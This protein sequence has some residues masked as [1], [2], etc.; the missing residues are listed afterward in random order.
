MSVR[1]ILFVGLLMC[2]AT[3]AHAIAVPTV[4]GFDTGAADWRGLTTAINPTWSAT[5]GVEGGFIST[6]QAINSSSQP[7]VFRAQVNAADPNGPVNSSNGAFAGNWLAAGADKVKLSVKH[8]ASVPLTFLIRI[9]PI[10]NTPGVQVQTAAPVPAGDNWVPL[11]FDLSFSNPLLS[12]GAGQ[13]W[14]IPYNTAMTT[15]TNFQVAVLRPGGWTTAPTF[16]T[17]F[18][19]SLDSVRVVPEPASV[20]LVAMSLV[21]CVM[22]LRI[23]RRAA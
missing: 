19:F 23:R 12:V 6:T 3:T 14:D 20:A 5:G 11:E 13:P 21:G 15:A 7:V 8:N 1:S 2:A 4:E 9:A 16:G 10:N 18:T 22:G 17:Q